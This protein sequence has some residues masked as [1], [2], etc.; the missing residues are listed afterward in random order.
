VTARSIV[1]VDG[2]NLYYGAVSG[3]PYKWLNLQKYFELIRTHDDI[4]VIRYFTALIDGSHR[5]HQET[6]LEAVATLPKVEVVLGRYKHN[7][8]TCRVAGCSYRKNRVFR[9]PEEKQTDVNIALWM[10][11]DAYQGLTDRMILVSGDSDLVPAINMVKA[12]FPAIDIVVYVP[13]SNPSRGAAVELRTAADKAR[14]LPLVELK[15]AQFPQVVRGRGN[16]IIQK[17]SGW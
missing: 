13:N 15:H 2:F 3:T 4:Q 12:R 6:Y 16:K 9:K 5:V 10:L 14:N 11:D 17:P 7:E 1:Y 8:V